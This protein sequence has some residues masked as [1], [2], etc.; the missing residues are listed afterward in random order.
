[1]RSS[2]YKALHS[3]DVV[4]RKFPIC[5]RLHAAFTHCKPILQVSYSCNAW[6]PHAHICYV[7]IDDHELACTFA[8]FST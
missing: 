5:V 8:P 4:V 1:M 2:L 7:H 3:H 6:H